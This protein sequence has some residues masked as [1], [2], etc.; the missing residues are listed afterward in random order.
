[1]LF[2][3]QGVNM[4]VYACLYDVE[5][6]VR[7]LVTQNTPNFRKGIEFSFSDLIISY[8]GH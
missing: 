3:L 5:I 7:C 2:I 1:M 4:Y 8:C 6:V